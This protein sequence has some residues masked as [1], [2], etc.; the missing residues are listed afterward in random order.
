MST[1]QGSS[2]RSVEPPSRFSFTFRCLVP[3][4]KS[5]CPLRTQLRGEKTPDLD[6]GRQNVTP[7][8]VVDGYQ[9]HMIGAGPIQQQLRGNRGRNGR[10][11]CG[12]KTWSR[13]VGNR[14]DSARPFLG[15]G[16]LLWADIDAPGWARLDT[17]SRWAEIVATSGQSCDQGSRP[18]CNDWRAS[19]VD[20]AAGEVDT[21]SYPKCYL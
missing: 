4:L 8:S 10:T 13:P 17:T 2:P 19:A 16:W 5:V 6:R 7:I 9:G 3:L 15:Q 21:R 11:C 20:K 18:T 12:E 14:F 1:T